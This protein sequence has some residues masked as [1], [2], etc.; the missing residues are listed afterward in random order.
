MKRILFSVAMAVLSTF[1]Y[2]QRAA[3][4]VISME[5]NITELTQNQLTGVVLVK[6]G[7][8]IHGIDSE[9]NAKLWSITEDQIGKSSA[10]DILNDTDLLNFV[11][12]KQSL[13][14]VP[15]TPF[16]EGIINYKFVLIN[17]E[18]G[19]I[20][21]NTANEKFTVIFSEMLYDSREYL[22]FVI[23][24]KK[25]KS[26]LIDLNTGEQKWKTAIGDSKSLLS[27]LLSIKNVVF[28]DKAM[29]Y[30]NKIFSLN[31]GL[32]SCL[33]RD[34]GELLWKTTDKYTNFFP[35]QNGK[36]IVVIESG[37][38]ISTKENL[39]VL[40]TE[41]GKG[42]WDKSIKT[43]KVVYLEDWG[44]KL[45]VAHYSGFNFFDLST[46]EKVWKKDARGD[47]LK[48]VIALGTDFL[49]VAEN[50]MMLIDYNGEKKWKKFIEIS[51][52]KEDEIIFLDK[53]G[54]KVFYLTQ[55]Y[56][57]MVEYQTGSKLWKR[58]I[59]FN[60]KRPVLSVYDK[61]DDVFLVYNDEKLFKFNPNIS[62]K[63]EEFAKVKVKNEKDLNNITLFPW[64][65]VLTGPEEI[66]GVGLD[67]QT[68]YANLYKQPGEGS[69]KLIKGAS[70]VGGV[71]LGLKSSYSSA[72]GSEWTMTYRDESGVMRESIVK[73]KDDKKLE[74]A[75]A[76]LAVSNTLFAVSDKFKKRFNA[77]KQDADFAYIF[78]KG[79]GNNP[80]LV[81]VRK[82]D[83]VEVDKILFSNV[84]P[85]YE[86]DEV[87]AN[88]FYANGKNLEVFKSK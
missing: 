50:E 88:I 72:M 54:D 8:N 63:P 55:T 4:S 78:A 35:T 53:V 85:V 29:A 15:G 46:G 49:Y 48:K 45:L 17:T 34:N 2:A 60:E 66:I 33:N 28:E 40:N 9:T 41:N 83:G 18:T 20:V 22:L 26:L 23:E 27:G 38:L 1:C 11:K 61:D 75:G 21:Y 31:Y 56:G 70:A 37:G 69:R 10:S 65:V 81:K 39:F 52:N 43:K 76:E 84:R 71:A 19:K 7:E 64:G 6:E 30:G 13:K 62:D 44:E 16:V 14:T 80:T 86:L 79:E 73:Q 5:K 12:D 87:T 36:N 24:D 82:S 77:L 3:N 32:L 25:V 57:N 42:I 74:Q 67:G 68:K 58:N 59:K 47:G 51:D